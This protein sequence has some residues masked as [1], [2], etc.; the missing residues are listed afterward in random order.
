MF[1]VLAVS[2]IE[3]FAFFGAVDGIIRLV[4]GSEVSTT[5]LAYSISIILQ[6]TA[7]RLFYPLAGFLADVYLGRYRVIHI[8]LWLLWIAFSFLAL[9]LSLNDLPH[10]SP[11]LTRYI[12]PVVAFVLHD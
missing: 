7:G 10:V 5:S 12:L 4:L 1:L 9:A 3:T 11:V 8:S 2:T 6:Y